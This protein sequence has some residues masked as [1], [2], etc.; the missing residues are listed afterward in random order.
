MSTMRLVCFVA[1]AVL[2]AVSI[3]WAQVEA[4][5]FVEACKYWSS[6][7]TVIGGA[8]LLVGGAAFAWSEVRNRVEKTED[9]IKDI[10]KREKERDEATDARLCR[11]DDRISALEQ[12]RDEQHEELLGHLR[13][14]EER[15]QRRD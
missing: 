2:G 9:A 12:K 6:T 4:G 3:V 11:H 8:V 7:V 10:R 15:L 5:G 13:R 14:L 1:A